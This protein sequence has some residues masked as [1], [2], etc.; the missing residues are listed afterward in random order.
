MGGHVLQILPSPMM[1]YM[2]FSQESSMYPYEALMNIHGPLALLHIIPPT[3][4]TWMGCGVKVGGRVYYDLL[5]KKSKH[6]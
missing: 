6:A 5:K 1:M 3:C 4:D 2:I